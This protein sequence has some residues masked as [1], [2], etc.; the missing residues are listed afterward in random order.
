MI[1]VASFEALNE[2]QNEM[3]SIKPINE[4]TT[5]LWQ[6]PSKGYSDILRASLS[7]GVDRF[8]VDVQLR[9]FAFSD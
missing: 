8:D 5:N 3:P 4:R 2:K 6:K 7:F 1:V 9:P